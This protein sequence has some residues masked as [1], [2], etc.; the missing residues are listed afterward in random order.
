MVVVPVLVDLGHRRTVRVLSEE[1]RYS[2]TIIQHEGLPEMF[3]HG[4]ERFLQER[5]QTSRTQQRVVYAS[6]L[7]P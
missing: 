6:S 5:R 2:F 1:F 7:L 3:V 4:F